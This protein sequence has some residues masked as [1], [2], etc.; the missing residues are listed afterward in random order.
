MEEAIS[1]RLS[2]VTIRRN[3]PL[4]HVVQ[5]GGIDFLEL[6]SG[7]EDEAEVEQRTEESKAAEEERTVKTEEKESEIPKEGL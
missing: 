5:E 7:S 2:N 3:R 6:D 4:Y 1:E